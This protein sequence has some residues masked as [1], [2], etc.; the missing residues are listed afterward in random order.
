MKISQDG[1]LVEKSEVW[2][3]RI[4]CSLEFLIDCPHILEDMRKQWEKEGRE[5]K[6]HY[7][8]FIGDD[9]RC[10]LVSLICRS[11]IQRAYYHRNAF[12]VTAPDDEIVEAVA[13][14]IA[15]NQH[16]QF[17]DDKPFMGYTNDDFVHNRMTAR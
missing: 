13:W 9:K 7:W 8:T 14:V 1:Q 11:E 12:H 2:E 3:Q 6:L 4:K 5:I 17:L 15:N 16:L 10:N